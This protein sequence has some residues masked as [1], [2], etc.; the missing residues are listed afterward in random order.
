MVGARTPRPHDFRCFKHVRPGRLA[1]NLRMDFWKTICLY[2][3][4]VFRFHVGLFQ[5]VGHLKSATNPNLEELGKKRL[6]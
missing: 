3:P 4:V 1:W 2:N 5:G 6:R